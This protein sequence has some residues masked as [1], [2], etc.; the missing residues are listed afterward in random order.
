MKEASRLRIWKYYNFL[1]VSRYF[2]YE[3]NFRK[4]IKEGH[5]SSFTK[6]FILAISTFDS[7]SYC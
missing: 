4:F 6:I 2:K 7:I 1:R 3:N 5:T